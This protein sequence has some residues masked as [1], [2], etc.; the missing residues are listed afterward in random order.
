MVHG[1]RQEE[2]EEAGLRRRRQ[3]DQKE[4]Q[5]QEEEAL[6]KVHDT[7]GFESTSTAKYSK[8]PSTR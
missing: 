4:Q 6:S 3:E 7:G 1:I 2:E 8:V 5:Q